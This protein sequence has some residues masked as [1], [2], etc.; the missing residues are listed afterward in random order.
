[1][2][3]HLWA[4]KQSALAALAKVV[5]P[6]DFLACDVGGSVGMVEASGWGATAGRSVAGCSCQARKGWLV[7]VTHQ[8]KMSSFRMSQRSVWSLSLATACRNSLSYLRAA[9]A[10]YAVK[11]W[12]MM[13]WYFTS[14][15]AVCGATWMGVTAKMFQV[16]IQEL[17]SE[18]CR[19]VQPF[20]A[21]WPICP[22]SSGGRSLSKRTYLPRFIF[23]I[24]CRFGVG[25]H[26]MNWDAKT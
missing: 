26:E 6:A 15:R 8:T 5:P 13:F 25:A 12:Q 1:M 11:S 20:L 18:T 21:A 7:L 22:S 24:S 2:T 4:K 9:A 23:R 17:R 16:S 19:L 3:Q 10:E 14:L